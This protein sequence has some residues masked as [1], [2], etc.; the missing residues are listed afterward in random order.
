MSMRDRDL[1]A[2]EVLT[3]L[4]QTGR[5]LVCA[6]SCTAGLVSAT[7]AGIPGASNYLCGSAVVYRN[8]TKT[9]WV[10]VPREVLDDPAR[11]D[12][13]EETATLMAQGVLAATSEASVS[14]SVTGHLGPGSPVGLD[15]VIYIGWAERDVNQRAISRSKCIRVELQEP[16]P[17]DRD[18]VPRR[19]A[20]QAA[21]TLSVLHVVRDALCQI[22][23]SSKGEC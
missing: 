19:V 14:V 4:E 22:V 7:L 9:E 18:D 6:E 5:R 3:L 17:Q 20:R 11:G 23:E 15:G 1:M 21:A 2:G 16:A 8:A 12:V 10:G 13:C